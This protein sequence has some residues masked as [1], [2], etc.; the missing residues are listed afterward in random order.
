MNISVAK[1][2]RSIPEVPQTLIGKFGLMAG[3]GKS[4]TPSQNGEGAS[5]LDSDRFLDARS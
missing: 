1:Y 3:Y 4:Q 2:S 5:N